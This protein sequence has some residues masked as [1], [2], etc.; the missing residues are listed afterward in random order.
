MFPPNHYHYWF[1]RV[2]SLAFFRY[3]FSSGKFFFSSPRVDP[4]LCWKPESHPELE[5]CAKL[6][7]IKFNSTRWCASIDDITMIERRLRTHK[8]G[9]ERSIGSAPAAYSTR[10]QNKAANFIQSDIPSISVVYL[11]NSLWPDLESVVRW[12]TTQLTLTTTAQ[13]SHVWPHLIE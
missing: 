7:L 11:R 2:S 12:K 4:T 1:V 10:K 13:H 5:C 6:C 3:Q 9:V 8:D